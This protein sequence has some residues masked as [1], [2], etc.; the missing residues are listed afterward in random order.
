LAIDL[1]VPAVSI[2]NI[3]KSLLTFENNY[4]NESFFRKVIHI[5][6]NPDLNQTQADLESQ[7]I[8][9]KLLTLTRYTELGF[10]LY[11]YPNNLKQAEK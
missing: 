4:E 7:M 8:P 9:E 5:L 3:Y 11:D 1:G 10:V 2:R 6:R